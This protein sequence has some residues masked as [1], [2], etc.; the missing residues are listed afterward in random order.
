METTSDDVAMILLS[1][2]G[3]NDPRGTYFFLPHDANMDKDTPLRTGVSTWDIQIVISSLPGTVLLF[4]DTC[5]SGNVVGGLKGGVADING[6]I[7]QLSSPENGAV[8]FAASTGTQASIED[9]KWSNG[10]FTK[11]VVE[12]IDGQADYHNTGEITLHSLADYISYRVEQLTEKQ[13]TPMT[14]ESNMIRNID[15]ALKR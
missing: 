5:H 8:V 1:G 2:H 15:I 11:A 4:V 12:G 6:L 13:Q 10:A 7:N 9:A 3:M 14:Q